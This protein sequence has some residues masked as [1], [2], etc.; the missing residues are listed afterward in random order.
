[1]HMKSNTTLLVLSTIVLAAGAY[2]FFFIGT[3][4]EAPLSETSSENSTQAKFKELIGKLP[5][6]FNT[7]IFADPRFNTLT[8]LTTQV[9]PELPGRIDPFAPVQTSGAQ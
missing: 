5:S 7:D 2:W 6:S 4:N 3:D 9:I 8:D 1:M